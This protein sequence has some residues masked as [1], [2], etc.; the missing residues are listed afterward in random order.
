M[1]LYNIFSRFKAGRFTNKHDVKEGGGGILANIKV[2]LIENKILHVAS[3]NF[4]MI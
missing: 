1:F 3:I 4:G 2:N